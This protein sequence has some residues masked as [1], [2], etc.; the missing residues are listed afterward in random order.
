MPSDL[1]LGTLLSKKQASHQAFIHSSIMF[2]LIHNILQ[3]YNNVCTSQQQSRRANVCVF[4]E[5]PIQQQFPRHLSPG[6][7]GSM[8]NLIDFFLC[9][10]RRL[11]CC[12]AGH[13]N[14]VFSANALC[15]CTLS[16]S[17]AVSLASEPSR[18]SAAPRHL[19]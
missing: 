3:H 13:G 5:V 8:L 19:L 16:A 14:F 11:G 15:I 10:R 9:T 4:S 17:A 7:K 1:T 12:D 2:T 6:P 18:H